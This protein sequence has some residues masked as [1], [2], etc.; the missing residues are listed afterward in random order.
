MIGGVTEHD[1][2]KPEANFTDEQ[3]ASLRKV[4]AD[5]K[6]KFPHAEILGHRDMPHVK[7]ACPSFDVR[8]WLN[9]P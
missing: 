8:H 1:V 6:T 9:S 4:L 2:N 3:Y 7:K 5:L